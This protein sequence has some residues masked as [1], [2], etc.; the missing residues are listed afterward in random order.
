MTSMQ[1]FSSPSVS[2][3]LLL[4]VAAG[5][6]V[7][8]SAQALEPAGG[9]TNLVADPLRGPDPR[10]LVLKAGTLR[11]DP[12]PGRVSDMLLNPAAAA[13][14][15]DGGAIAAD[16]DLNGRFVVQLDG[17]M[18]PQRRVALERSGVRLGE[19]LPAN[20]Y[21]VTF[22]G[23]NSVLALDTLPFVQWASPF[24]GEWKIDPGIGRRAGYQEPL[25]QQIA[26]RGETLVWVYLFP[27][28]DE[29]AAEAALRA[30]G[31]TVLKSGERNG[32]NPV[33][34]ATVR[35]GA[36]A[37]ISAIKSVQYVEEVP[38]AVER[39]NGSRT[40]V[41]SGLAGLTPF[42]NN[43]IN[44]AGQVVGLLD[45][46]MDVN[47]CSFRDPNGNPIG[48][49][50]RKILAFNA[51]AGTAASHGTHTA[52]TLTG[53]NNLNDDTRG[54]A[55]LAKI[56]FNLTPS[57]ADLTLANN[58][59]L[60]TRLNQHHSQGA[61]VHSNSWGADGRTDY[62]GWTRAIDVFSRNNEDSLVAFAVSNGS[63]ATTPE[64]AKSCLA[65]GGV[66]DVPNINNFCT[67]GTG[68][69][70]DGRR[71]PE[72][73]APGC[74]ILSSSANTTCSVV[75]LTGT[76]M[77][78]PA[79]TGAAALMREYFA[80]GFYPAGA[81]G[82]PAQNP[83]GALTRA[84]I[85][86]AGQDITNMGGGYP[87][88]AEGWGRLVGDQSAFFAGDTRKLAV[89]DVRNADFNSLTT[90][91]VN[92]RRFSVNSSTEQLRVTLTFTDVAASLSASS[93]PVN[94]ILLEVIAPDG[95]TT[96]RG[97]NFSGGVTIPG[98]GFIDNINS[99]E[100][101]HINTPAVGLWTVRITGTA[102][103]Q[104]TQGYGLVVTGDVAWASAC[105]GD[106]SGDNAVTFADLNAVLG[107]FGQTGLNLPADA[108]FDGQVNFSDLNL[109]LS[110]FGA[111]CD[112][113]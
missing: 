41:Q 15:N 28:E 19:Y 79:I 9:K 68:P 84:M 8:A 80:D 111:A 105:P 12:R 89:W 112:G 37:A 99:T 61:R 14:L 97:N 60:E 43:G 39:N 49:T 44:G 93:T 85:L 57:S 82:G 36:A 95:V 86:N 75:S 33:I 55:Y 3:C 66:Q 22:A 24:L 77:A 58:T 38:E 21:I 5:G 34:T 30:T 56:V 17:P 73:F 26:A 98:T 92:S 91:A 47:H 110:N 76:S 10:T 54:V 31:A 2:V 81:L 74:S 45:S 65:V 29:N 94:N 18:T 46:R 83:T 69:T 42:Y 96:Y 100:Q 107:A 50:H 52:G 23:R 32:E 35:A 13:L 67:G 102:V 6:A 51:T 87:S 11:T 78:C 70:A 1:R 72:I 104:Q 7:S 88:N 27:G 63:T 113:Q 40:S 25:R 20:A 109:I 53:D 108:N 103:N 59:Q 106:V 16:P 4:L 62:N 71:K 101:V 64:N 90:G 48:P